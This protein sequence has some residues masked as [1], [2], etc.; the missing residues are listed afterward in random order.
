MHS[1]ESA[2]GR[3]MGKTIF[4]TGAGGFVGSHSVLE[5]LEGEILT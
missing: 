4:V 5:L 3:E 1:P 2:V